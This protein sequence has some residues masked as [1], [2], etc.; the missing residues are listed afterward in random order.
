MLFGNAIYIGIRPTRDRKP[1]TLAALDSDL[2]LVST[3]QDDLEDAMAYVAGHSAAIVAVGAPRGPARGLLKDRRRRGELG[4]SPEGS[5]WSKWRVASYE[6]RRRNIHMVSVAT[7]LANAGD[8]LELGFRIFARLDELG[9]RP[10]QRGEE[11]KMRTVIE[12]QPQAAFSVLLGRQPLPKDALE[13]RLQRQLALYLEGLEIPNPM[14]SLEEV[15]RHHL[16]RGE[17]PLEDLASADELDALVAA[18]TAYRVGRAS[19]EVV[20]VGDPQEGLITLPASE[21]K[22]SYS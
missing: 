10:F 14:R 11:P 7:Q 3:H 12:V 19:D 22:D 20:Q 8:W 5:T 6:L 9:Y 17:L 2:R 4:L 16:L 21:L 13:G 15:T 18:Y 1:L